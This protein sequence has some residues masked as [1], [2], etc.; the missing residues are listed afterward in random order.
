M[1]A[2]VRPDQ[3]TEMMNEIRVPCERPA[4]N[5]EA[6]KYGNEASADC[7]GHNAAEW[8]LWV[9]CGCPPPYVLYCTFCKD[10]VLGAPMLRCGDCGLHVPGHQ[11]YR[12]VEPLN[13][14]AA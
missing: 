5:A 3:F 13:R 9:A 4:R 11:M 1:N 7:E 2:D 6:A 8:V 14:A 12:R 10:V